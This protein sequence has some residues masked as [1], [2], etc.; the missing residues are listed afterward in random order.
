MKRSAS[1]QL[2][3]A[4]RAHLTASAAKLGVA[5]D[6]AAVERFAAFAALLDLW[7]SRTNL[8]SCRSAREL[9]DRHLVDS[10]VVAR[11]V[12]DGAT[13]ADLGS[14]AGFPGVPLAIAR[15]P[16][17]VIL[18]E[19]RQRRGSFLHEVARCVAPNVVVAVRRAETADGPPTPVDVVVSRAVWS[20]AT[21]VDLAAP[22]LHS[23]GVLVW[24]RGAD[25]RLDPNASRVL[26]HRESIDYEIAGSHRG[27]VEVL[28]KS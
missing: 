14:G 10:L 28:V 26:G 20:D 23:G 13:I 9:V 18:V 12:S 19:P 2:G 4:E 27:R 21:A 7:A 16:C 25:Q 1:L 17:R 15:P 3:E 11:F 8:V 24:I 22:W 6:A 5:L